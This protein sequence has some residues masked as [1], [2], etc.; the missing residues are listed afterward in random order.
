[1]L[2][3]FLPTIIDKIFRTKSRN[4]VK[5]FD[6]CLCVLFDCYYQRLISGRRTGHQVISPPKFEIFLIFLNFLGSSVLSHLVTRETTPRLNLLY[7]FLSLVLL[8]ANLTCAKTLQRF[9]FA[10]FSSNDHSRFWKKQSSGSKI[11]VQSKKSFL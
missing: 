2:P 7:Y 5:F 9:Y 1:M 6:I 3:T 11:C 8:A 10:L 4:P